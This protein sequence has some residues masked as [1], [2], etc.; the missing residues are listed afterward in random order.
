MFW[1]FFNNKG[2]NTRIFENKVISEGI[3][4]WLLNLISTNNIHCNKL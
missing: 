4:I 1:K 3:V 2:Q